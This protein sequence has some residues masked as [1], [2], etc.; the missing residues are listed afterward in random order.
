MNRDILIVAQYTQAPGEFENDRFRYIAEMIRALDPEVHVEIVTMSFSHHLKVQRSVSLEQLKAWKYDMTFIPVNSYR[1]NVSARRLIS[2]HQMGSGL[3]KYLRKRKKPDVIYCAVPS[4]D[5]GYTVA[6]YAK[7]NTIP[8]IVDVQDIWPEAFKLVFHVP[9]LSS[10]LF[11]P[12][13]QK[14]NFIYQCADYVLA[15][16]KTYAERAMRV[17][18]KCTKEMVVFL[19]TELSSFDKLAELVAAEREKHDNDVY[20][21]YV[22]TLGQSYDLTCVIDALSILKEN[23]HSEFHFLIM[24]DGP[25]QGRFMEHAKASGIDAEFT[26]RLPY[27]EMVKRLVACD[28]AVNPIQGGAA[29]SI[30]NKHADYAAAGLPVINTQ[31]SVEYQGLLAVYQAGITCKNGDVQDMVDKLLL[32]GKNRELR[33]QMG[34]NS[35]RMAEERFDRGNTYSQIVSLLIGED[36]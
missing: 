12:M 24:G 29:Q 18:S 35:R 7:E 15:V 34:A 21:A 1:K 3:S 14:A 13:E 26:G 6:K 22:G 36:K 30:I 20:V 16:S 2:N 19:G 28:I 32:L 25:Q 10:I 9:V 17:N 31:E 11:Y 27:K 33:K 4:L 23:G 5:A 8:F